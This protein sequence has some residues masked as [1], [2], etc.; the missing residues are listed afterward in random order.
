MTTELAE[1]VK[2]IAEVK[3]VPFENIAF[4]GSSAGG[5][6]ALALSAKVEGST[7]VAINPQVDSMAY[8]G[9]SQVDLVAQTCNEMTKEDIKDRFQ[10]RVD[11]KSAWSENDK[12]KAFFV[13][14]LED[15]H[16]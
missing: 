8:S 4:Y 1:F 9:V 2:R 16:H 13:Q 6:A 5:F 12:S 11:M 7:A 14:N 15:G 10:N 3:G